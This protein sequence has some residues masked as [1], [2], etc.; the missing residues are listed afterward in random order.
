MHQDGP[1]DMGCDST[2]LTLVVWDE[3]VIV[4]IITL[5]N[6]NCSDKPIINKRIV[7]N[8]LIDVNIECI[9]EV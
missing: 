7:L 9:K 2:K 6:I 5:S 8:D 1:N 4:R 3:T